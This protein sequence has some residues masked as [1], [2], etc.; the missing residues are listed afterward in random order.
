MPPALGSA[1]CPTIEMNATAFALSVAFSRIVIVPVTVAGAATTAVAGSQERGQN[2]DR[3]QRGQLAGHRVLRCDGGSRQASPFEQTRASRV[4][5]DTPPGL[6]SPRDARL[7]R[8]RRYDA[9]PT[10][11]PRGDAPV[12]RRNVRQPVVGALVRPARPRGAR[13]CP[14]APGPVDRRRRTGDRVH[15]RRHGGEQPRPQGCRVGR[16]GARPSHRDHRRSSTTPSATH[17]TTCRSSA[18]RSSRSRWTGT[19]ASTPRTSS[20]P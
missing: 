4:L 17:S 11:G 13:R 10:R 1:C 2:R 18:S 15:Q 6:Q 12:P 16:Q 9:R 20:A 14:R 3:D 8:P 19:A 7:P 5:G